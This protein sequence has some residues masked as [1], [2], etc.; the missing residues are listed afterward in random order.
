MTIIG[1]DRAE[2]IIFNWLFAFNECLS[3][4]FQINT[5]LKKFILQ[6]HAYVP[7]QASLYMIYRQFWPEIFS[8]IC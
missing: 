5:Y 8:I 6:M 2:N 7:L 4:R 3:N 1:I